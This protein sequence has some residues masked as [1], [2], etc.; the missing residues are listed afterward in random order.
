MT[1]NQIEFWK[2]EEQKR[3]NRAQEGETARHNVVTEQETR[4][5][6]VTT[7]GETERSNRAREGIDLSKL[8]ETSRHNK[9]TEGETTRHNVAT[10]NLD[11]SKLAETTRHNRQTEYLTGADIGERARHNMAS[12]ALSGRQIDVAL[13]N[14]DE[15]ST[16]NRST[17]GIQRYAAL[18]Q[19]ELN[20]ANAALSNVK[21]D[22]TAIMNSASLSLTDNQKQQIQ[23]QINKLQAETS[24]L[25]KQGDWY[26]Y[27]QV[28]DGLD[29][30]SRIMSA[31]D[32]AQRGISGFLNDDGRKQRNYNSYLDSLLEEIRNEN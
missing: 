26:T 3:S 1:R 24:L 32:D 14:L 22:W 31:L 23:S 13:A 28:L 29:T 8:A 10:E 30:V 18:S 6:N 21:R 4:R 19:G 2:N 9:V 11:L 12:E 27:Q 7:E 20:E 17:E 15:L 16:H 25:N 5:H